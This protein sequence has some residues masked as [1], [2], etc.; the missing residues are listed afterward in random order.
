MF[1]MSLRRRL[2]FALGVT[3]GPPEGVG[4]VRVGGVVG[5]GMITGPLGVGVTVI[6]GGWVMTGGGRTVTGE[7]SIAAIPPDS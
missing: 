5:A 3:I 6:G 1:S 2:N 4:G 7:A